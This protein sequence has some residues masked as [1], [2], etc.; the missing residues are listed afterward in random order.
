MVPFALH[1]EGRQREE[2]RETLICRNIPKSAPQASF[3]KS[4]RVS[5]AKVTRFSS[6]TQNKPAIPGAGTTGSGLRAEVWTRQ[7]KQV[8][9]PQSFHKH[10]P[11]KHR[12]TKTHRTRE[13]AGA[14]GAADVYSADKQFLKECSQK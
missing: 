4:R 14:A 2:T 3:F 10:P 1:E 8:T 12:G 11:E 13:R 5:R 7:I 6:R 9:Y